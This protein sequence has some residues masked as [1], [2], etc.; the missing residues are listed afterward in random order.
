MTKCNRCGGGLVWA[1]DVPRGKWSAVDPK[2]VRKTGEKRLS[3]GAL[4]LRTWHVFHRC[5]QATV[6]VPDDVADALAILHLRASAP[7]PVIDAAWKALVRVHHPDVGG[8]AELCKM[9][10][11]ARDV[12]LDWKDQ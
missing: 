9:I 11:A 5:G 3:N 10:N 8:D 12:V 6:Q 4:Q 1:W 2:S 7:L